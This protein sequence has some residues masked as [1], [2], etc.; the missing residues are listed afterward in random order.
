MNIAVIGQEKTVE[1]V[2]G[3][4][5]ARVGYQSSCKQSGRVFVVGISLTVEKIAS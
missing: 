4:Y 2:C 1:L 3:L 5:I